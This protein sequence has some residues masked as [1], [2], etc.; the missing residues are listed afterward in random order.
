MIKAVLF[1]LDGLLVDTEVVSLKIYQEIVSE[2]GFQFSK[3]EYAKHYS[4]KTEVEN[5]HRLIDTY[6]LSLTHQECL[7]K[8]LDMEQKLITQG[9][10]LKA[11]VKPLLQF[12]NKNHFKIALATSSTR[13][14]AISILKRHNILHYFDAFVFSEDVNSS[15]PN[16][17]VFLITCE[18]LHVAPE[19]AIVLEDSENGIM[20]AYNAHIP[21]ICI[22]DMKKPTQD[23]LDK[24]LRVYETLNDVIS[25]LQSCIKEK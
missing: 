15:K 10:E 17:E 21:V 3:E 20:A 16:P 11:G 19:E 13:E 24:A 6:H 2:Y 9:V 12:L 22:P 25:Y 14:R 4:G 23:Y 8:V 18:K 7:D 5:I 1:D